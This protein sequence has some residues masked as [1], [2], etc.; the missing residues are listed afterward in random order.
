MMLIF[1]VI[2]KNAFLMNIYSYDEKQVGSLFVNHKI[3]LIIIDIF[4]L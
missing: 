3:H 1:I 2:D 4:F